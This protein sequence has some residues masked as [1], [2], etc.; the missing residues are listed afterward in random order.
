MRREVSGFGNN[1]RGSGISS[2]SGMFQHLLP[3]VI[4]LTLFCSYKS[5]LLDLTTN[6]FNLG[7]WTS[8]ALKTFLT[9]TL[10]L[11]TL[12]IYVGV[13]TVLEKH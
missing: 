5:L 10:G 7:D 1:V 13:T 12:Q 4:L 8:L 2:G 6:A 9:T 11:I 3:L